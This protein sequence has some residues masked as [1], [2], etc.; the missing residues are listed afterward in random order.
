MPTF[1]VAAKEVHTRRKAVWS[2]GKHVDQRIN[3]LRD[4]AF[5]LI[6]H[7]PV[8]QIGTPEVLKVLTPVWTTKPETARRVRQRLAL[9]LDWAR[10]HK[11]KSKVEAA[12]RRGHMRVNQR[13]LMAAWAGYVRG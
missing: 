5:P 11:I 2:N 13:E 9:V 7:L 8:D 6:G 1:E 3:T 10:A 4:Y 12:Y